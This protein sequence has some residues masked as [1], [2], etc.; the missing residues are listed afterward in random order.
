MARLKSAY[1]EKPQPELSPQPTIP[2]VKIDGHDEPE[3]IAA[4]SV[5]IPAAEQPNE[6]VVA[7]VQGQEKADEA[8]NALRKQIANLQRAEKLQRQHLM[9]LDEKIEFWREGGLSDR[10]ADFLRANPA[11]MPDLI[12]Y[13]A[14][15]ALHEGYERDT[16]DYFEAVK[17]NFQEG[18][19]QLQAQAA[20]N[21]PEFFRPPPPKQPAP[22]A[23]AMTYSAPVSREV[24][25]AGPRVETNPSQVRLSAEEVDIAK[26]SGISLTEY[27]RQKLRLE[28]EKRAGIRQ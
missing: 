26:A 3:S 13:A 11:D 23:S 4:V 2:E 19:K 22:G 27:A 28:A 10:E 1:R 18:M 6:A 16:E 14:N 21:A 20:A 9:S 25:T 12:Y 5:D 15:K 17:E 8:A 7:A 24:P